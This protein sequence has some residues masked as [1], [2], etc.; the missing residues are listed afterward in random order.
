MHMSYVGLYRG[1]VSLASRKTGY[2]SQEMRPKF[3]V[4]QNV[5]FHFHYKLFCIKA[6][7]L[8]DTLS[9]MCPRLWPIEDGSVFVYL[10]VF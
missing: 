6:V 5:Y 7:H 4:S 2:D 1:Q 8:S 9:L 10:Y 3:I